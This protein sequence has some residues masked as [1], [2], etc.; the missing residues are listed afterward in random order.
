MQ[1]VDGNEKIQ[2]LSQ[3]SDP[4]RVDEN[5][6][7]A[8]VYEKSD[9]LNSDGK[10]YYDSYMVLF[11]EN[12]DKCLSLVAIAHDSNWFEKDPD[13]GKMMVFYNNT[14]PGKEVV[15]GEFEALP[16]YEH[17]K[18]MKDRVLKELSKYNDARG[19]LNYKK[20][21]KNR[22]NLILGQKLKEALMTSKISEKIR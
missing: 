7:Q 21:N 5:H 6:I 4:S 18:K 19:L 13:S 2:V 10:V 11:E 3:S 20:N 14:M 12:K 9:R 15:S 16:A 22:P 1:I 8:L 17:A